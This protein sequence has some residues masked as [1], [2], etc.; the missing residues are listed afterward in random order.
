MGAGDVRT[1]DRQLAES[2]HALSVENAREGGGGAAFGVA[3]F[4]GLTEVC[5]LCGLRE[6]GRVG[7]R[8]EGGG[9]WVFKKSWFFDRERGGREGKKNELVSYI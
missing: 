7:G 5:H 3:W 6:R 2:A 4:P 8:G 1:L 9:R